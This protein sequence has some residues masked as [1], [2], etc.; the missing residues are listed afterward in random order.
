MSYYVVHDELYHHGILGQKWGIRR[1]Q[2]ADGSL[3]AQGKKRYHASSVKETV[4]EDRTRYNSDV[5]VTKHL[6]KARKLYDESNKSVDAYRKSGWY[7]YKHESYANHYN[8]RANK[9]Y[10]KAVKEFSKHN[11]GKMNADN[12]V[13]NFNKVR[14]KNGK[15][16]VEKQKGDSIKQYGRETLIN[17]GYSAV[18]SAIT[19]PLTGF[20]IVPNPIPSATV[21]NKY[22]IKE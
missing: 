20:V 8:M 11:S 5:K 17:L 10:D 4:G 9:Q 1:Y 21:I 15:N 16:F 2:N 18:A 13:E 3:T 12:Y 7:K 19:L 22:K 6:R 14:Q